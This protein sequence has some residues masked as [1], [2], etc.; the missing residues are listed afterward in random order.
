MYRGTEQLIPM[1]MNQQ[2]IALLA[3]LKEAGKCSGPS[4]VMAPASLIANWENEF[5]LWTPSL[6]IVSYKGNAG[7]RQGIFTAQVPFA[8]YPHGCVAKANFALS[9]QVPECQSKML[10]SRQNIQA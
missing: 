6:K 5:A 1:H 7:E 4:L 3:H 8:R 9:L 10:P 2:V